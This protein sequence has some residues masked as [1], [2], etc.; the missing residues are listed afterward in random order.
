MSEFNFENMTGSELS[1]WRKARNYSYEELRLML[2]I[3]SRQRIY[4]WEKRTEEKLPRT[5]RLA[6]MAIEYLPDLA[7]SNVGKR[8]NREGRSC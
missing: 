2:E 8:S 3:G 7:Y 5:I 1:V 4:N 6:L